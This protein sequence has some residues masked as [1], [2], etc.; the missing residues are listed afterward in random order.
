MKPRYRQLTPPQRY[1]IQALLKAGCSQAAIAQQ[2]DCH[3]STISRELARCPGEC[4]Q[5]KKAQLASDVRRTDAYKANKYTAERLAIIRHCLKRFLSPEMIANR[6]ALE[7]GYEIL[8]TATIYRWIEWDWYR[9]G[10]LH[11]YLQRAYN[12]YRTRYGVPD[13]RQQLG[14]RRSIHDRPSVVDVRS[15]CGDWEGDTMYGKGGHL[16]TLVDR[17]SRYFKAR[18]VPV[19][20]KK[21]TADSVINML[22]GQPAHTLTLDNGVEFASHQAI[23]KRSGATVYFAD[24]YASWQRGSNEN[25]NGRL[26]RF[27]PRTTDLSKLSSQKLRRLVERLNMQPRKCLGWKTPYEVH[28][29]VSVAL[30]M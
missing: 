12:S 14:D 7:T 8:S 24:T 27:I 10:T 15:R 18:K 4:Y 3:R 1:Q 21:R 25:A 29:G 30:I 22:R 16:V 5:A 9:G 23:E 13:R 11:R 2:L 28:F 26:R 20:T 19:R 6:L 17:C